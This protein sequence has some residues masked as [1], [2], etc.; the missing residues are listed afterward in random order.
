[1]GGNKASANIT[2]KPD[3]SIHEEGGLMIHATRS[4]MCLAG[5]KSVAGDLNYRSNGRRLTMHIRR[6]VMMLKAHAA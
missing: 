6:R 2:E 4:P 5:R 1:V 3:G